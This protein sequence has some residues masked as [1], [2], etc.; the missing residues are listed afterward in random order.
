MPPIFVE[1]SIGIIQSWM[2]GFESNQPPLQR[3]LPLEEA[4]RRTESIAL[5]I[6]PR[7][8][9]QQGQEPMIW[10]GRQGLAPIQQTKFA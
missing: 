10:L 8:T 1:K 4:R 5:T 2:R 7:Q 9:Y 3:L 6:W